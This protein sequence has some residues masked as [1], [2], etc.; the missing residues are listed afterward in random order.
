MIETVDHDRPPVLNRSDIVLSPSSLGTQ[1]DITTDFTSE[2]SEFSEGSLQG[3][4][5]KASFEKTIG[6][7]PVP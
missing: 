4:F 7:P 6:A 2:F 5:M 3:G 1:F